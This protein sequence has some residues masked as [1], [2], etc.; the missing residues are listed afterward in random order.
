MSNFNHRDLFELA[1]HVKSL[2]VKARG[3]FG[4]RGRP[5][6][7][8]GSASR[9]HVAG[10]YG[11]DKVATGS[12]AEEQRKQVVANRQA[13]AASGGYTGEQKVAQPKKM[14]AYELERT[15]ASVSMYG[16]HSALD[17]L[18]IQTDAQLKDLHSQISS[19]KPKRG[20]KQMDRR[21]ALRYIEGE[22][23]LRRGQQK[24][25]DLKG[26]SGFRK[27]RA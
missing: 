26:G 3:N 11:A 18:K 27:S 25:L 17:P 22:M 19:W 8:G 24:S 6:Q 20:D 9:G 5:G 4:H 2:D 13:H 1:R 21:I 10:G 16:G 23:L 14:S 12:S 15:A 7:R